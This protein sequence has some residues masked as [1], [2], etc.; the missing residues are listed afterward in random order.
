M[1]RKKPEGHPPIRQSLEDVVAAHKEL[2]PHLIA[3]VTL[4][5]AVADELDGG[6]TSNAALVKQYRDLL[7][8]LAVDDGSTDPIEEL[9]RKLR[10]QEEAEPPE[11]ARKGRSGGASAR[12]RADAVAAPGGGG[13]NR[14]RPGDG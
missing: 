11:P 1:P 3:V 12:V 5:R 8:G 2:S 14:V 10:D 4:A 9:L 7:E 6:Q 13:R